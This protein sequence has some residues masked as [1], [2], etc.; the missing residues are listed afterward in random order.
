MPGVQKRLAELD[1]LMAQ[2]NFW[3]NREKAQGLIDEAN[4]LRKK[5]EPVL[6]AER[7]VEDFRVMLELAQE[8]PPAEQARH[9]AESDAS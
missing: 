9:E 3:N 2:E 5:T 8:E 1:A 7:Q 4:S 6:K